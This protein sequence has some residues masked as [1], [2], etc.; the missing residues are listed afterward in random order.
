MIFELWLF[1]VREYAR[2]LR[3]VAY[4]AVEERWW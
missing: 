3:Q 4:I 2:L 1:V